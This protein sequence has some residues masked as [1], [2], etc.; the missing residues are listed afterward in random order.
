MDK[1]VLLEKAGKALKSF[2]HK[3]KIFTGEMLLLFGKWLSD[4]RK[5]R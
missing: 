4:N 3:L 5:N 2:L 1:D